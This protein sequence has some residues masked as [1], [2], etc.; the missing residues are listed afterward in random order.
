MAGELEAQTI[1][2]VVPAAQRN[3]DRWPVE[4]HTPDVQYFGEGYAEA[5]ESSEICPFGQIITNDDGDSAIRGGVIIAGNDT[6]N[7]DSEEINLGSLGEFLYYIDVNVTVNTDDDNVILM[8][9]IKTSS[10]PDWNRTS[11]NNYPSGTSPTAE[12]ASGRVIVAIGKLTV[13]LPRDSNNNGT[14]SFEAV[15]CGVI[16][17]NHCAGNLSAQRD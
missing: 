8:P 13:S 10:S 4:Y 9:G 6:Y 7:V 5:A 11:S 1:L 14:P 15:G 2:D 3:R 17:I 16:R 12:S